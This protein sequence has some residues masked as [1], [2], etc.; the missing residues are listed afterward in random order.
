MPDIRRLLVRAP[1]GQHVSVIFLHH[2]SLFSP[3]AS[4]SRRFFFPPLRLADADL[5]RLR[6]LFFFPDLPPPPL[7]ESSL[8]PRLRLRF[9][10]FLLFF[11]FFAFFDDSLSFSPRASCG[12]KNRATR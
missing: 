9:R 7:S 11:S 2:Y 8:P 3:F 12:S 10:C 6:L 1:A 4:A 5:E